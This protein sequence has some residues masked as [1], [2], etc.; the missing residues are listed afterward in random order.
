ME[1]SLYKNYNIF[2]LSNSNV[3]IKYYKLGFKFFINYVVLLKYFCLISPCRAPMYVHNAIAP[4]KCI[5]LY[6]AN[7]SHGGATKMIAHLG[8]HYGN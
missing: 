5:F 4:K 1:L 8:F 2:N 7:V 3:L 6:L